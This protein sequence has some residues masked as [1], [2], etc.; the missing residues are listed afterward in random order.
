MERPRAPLGMREGRGRRTLRALMDEDWALL[1]S[2]VE[3]THLNKLSMR[4]AQRCFDLYK[5]GYLYTDAQGL[6]SLSLHG[7]RELAKW[8]RASQSPRD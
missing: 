1:A 7:K 2:L 5:A 3:A 6:V 8:L 4:N